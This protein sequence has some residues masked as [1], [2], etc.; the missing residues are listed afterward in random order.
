MNNTSKAIRTYSLTVCFT[1]LFAAAFAFTGA[2]YNALEFYFPE[3]MNPGLKRQNEAAREAIMT[4]LSS[5]ESRKNLTEQQQN[6]LELL[7][8]MPIE[9][10]Y[11]NHTDRAFKPLIRSLIALFVCALIFAVHWRVANNLATGS[12]LPR[13]NSRKDSKQSGDV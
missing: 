13:N 1:S 11:L 6:A 7:P 5:P 4:L 10:D 3:T 8:A 12:A 2:T 9:I